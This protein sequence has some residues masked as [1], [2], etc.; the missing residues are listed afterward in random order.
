MTSLH[1]VTYIQIWTHC[2]RKLS[3]FPNL[4]AAVTS[5]IHP[6]RDTHWK[7]PLYGW[8]LDQEEHWGGM[9]QAQEQKLVK[10]LL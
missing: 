10:G 2:S 3:L 4:L 1:E 9:I 5:G 8:L 7:C 6:D